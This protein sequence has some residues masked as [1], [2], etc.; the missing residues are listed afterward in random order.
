MYG[1][2]S[3]HVLVVEMLKILSLTH[4]AYRATSSGQNWERKAIA[5][6]QGSMAQ[7]II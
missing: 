3:L 1:R 6:Q 7:P 4:A 5:H 2:L